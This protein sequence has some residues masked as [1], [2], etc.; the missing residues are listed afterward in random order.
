MAAYSYS[1]IHFLIWDSAAQ[2]VNSFRV[3]VDY[4]KAAKEADNKHS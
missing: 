1:K 3:I 2:P 4:L